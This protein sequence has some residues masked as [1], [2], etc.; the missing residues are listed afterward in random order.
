MAD[1]VKGDSGS[2]LRVTCVGTD[3][4]I[5][6]LTGYSVLLKYRIGSTI[7]TQ[8][9]MTVLSPAT[10]GVA[11]YT[12]ASADLGNEGIMYAEIEVTVGG[13]PGTLISSADPLIFTVRG[14]TI[15][16]E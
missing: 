11:E 7:Y 14:K 1:F 4:E 10:D 16:Q 8:K 13:G 12:F 15:T 5:F 2:K 3:G 9:N 6:N